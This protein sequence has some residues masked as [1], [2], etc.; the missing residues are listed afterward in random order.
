MLSVILAGYLTT[1]LDKIVSLQSNWSVLE[2][3]SKHSQQMLSGAEVGTLG[4]P[5]QRLIANQLYLF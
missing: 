4:R 5:F 1:I 2:L 3:F